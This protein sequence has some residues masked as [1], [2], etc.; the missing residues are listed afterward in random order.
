METK[1]VLIAKIKERSGNPNQMN[2]KEIDALKSSIQKYG[3]L[4]H[5]VLDSEMNLIDGHQRLRSCK[6][7]GLLEI[8]S[9]VLNLNDKKEKILLSHILN[10]HG[11]N[12][13]ELAALDYKELLEGID[14]EELSS[15]LAISEQEI[16]KVLNEKSLD[17]DIGKVER[18]HQRLITCPFCNK[19]FTK[20]DK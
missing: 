9:I 20:E 18:T 4:G 15:S 7:L 5:V 6:E 17:E 1:N 14:L 10:L 8:P 3:F 16:L 2:R 13:I 12:D 19:Q 11:T